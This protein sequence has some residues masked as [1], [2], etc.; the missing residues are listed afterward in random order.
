MTRCLFTL[1]DYLDGMR[2]VG[3]RSFISIH[4]GQ[5]FLWLREEPG[6]CKRYVDTRI[7]NPRCEVRP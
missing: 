7:G 1:P 3:L 6:A 2:D 4:G 5:K